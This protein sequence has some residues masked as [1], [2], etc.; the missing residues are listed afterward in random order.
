MWFGMGF[1]LLGFG[2]EAHSVHGPNSPTLLFFLSH[3][4]FLRVAAQ[5][6]PKMKLIVVCVHWFEQ[7]PLKWKKK[8]QNCKKI[9]GI[10]KTRYCDM[11]PNCP[12]NH[13]ESV[14]VMSDKNKD[15][16][17]LCKIKWL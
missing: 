4:R 8:Q 13:T 16:S 2:L 11:R 9:K 10:I 17:R 7:A 6:L 14:C 1:M 12:Q 15:L 5:S 3:S